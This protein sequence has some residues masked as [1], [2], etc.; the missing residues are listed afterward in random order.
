[1]KI[2]EH[3]VEKILIKFDD[4]DCDLE[5]L[6]KVLAEEH[7]LLIAY[8]LSENFA[9]LSEEEADYFQY[10]SLV[11]IDCCNTFIG[12]INQY[13]QEDV[14]HAEENNWKIME[15]GGAKT[16]NDKITVFFENSEEEDLLAFI[17]DSLTPEDGDFV[18]PV[19]RELMFV[20]LKTM[21]DVLCSQAI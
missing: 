12:D 16:F 19:G 8:L 9:L 4:D 13:N 2:N 17:E 10:L 6:M 15:E 20:G 1:M 14:D 7:E 3:Q 21:V 11:A 5:Q 18:T